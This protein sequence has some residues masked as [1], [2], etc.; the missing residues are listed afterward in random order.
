MVNCRGTI[1]K[2]G[3]NKIEKINMIIT[4]ETKET[5]FYNRKTF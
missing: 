3:E 2:P 1:T 4:G 5:D